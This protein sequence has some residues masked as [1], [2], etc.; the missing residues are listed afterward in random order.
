MYVVSRL[1]TDLSG[2]MGVDDT[3]GLD[4]STNYQSRNRAF[5]DVIQNL[6]RRIYQIK[7]RAFCD[8]IQNLNRGIYLTRNRAFGDVIQT[9]LSK[10]KQSIR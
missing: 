10:Q 6:N 5:S 2:F 1:A 3:N 7:N 9:N 8:V 4:I